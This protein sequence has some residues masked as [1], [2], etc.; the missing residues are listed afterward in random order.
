MKD[1][2][3]EITAAL[4]SS[5]LDLPSSLRTLLHDYLEKHPGPDDESSPK[6]HE[7]LQSIYDAHVAQSPARLA[8]F[9]SILFI[10]KPTLAGNGRLLQWWENLRD[11]VLEN[12]REKGLSKEVRSILLR[13][14]IWDEDDRPSTN[15]GVLDDKRATAS[16]I[17]NNLVQI[18]ITKHRLNLDFPEKYTLF[19]EDQLQQILY[20]F[21]RK[22]PKVRPLL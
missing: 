22:R 13:I 7:E 15:D 21:G 8:P 10:L 18:W 4:T 2:S 6:L 11:I 20:L 14:L 12:L 16:T 5:N 3:R 17:A 9:F 1:L 19:V